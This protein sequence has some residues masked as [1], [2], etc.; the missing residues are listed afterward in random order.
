MSSV[1]LYLVG[2]GLVAVQRVFE[3]VLSQR[4]ASRA[5]A[6]G[7]VE[8]GQ[9]HLRA[10]SALHIAFFFGCAVE[11]WALGRP[12][13]ASV[14]VPMIAVALAA[15]SL[16]AWTMWS[17]GDAWN[18]R[19]IVV[20]G[21]PVVTSGP[22]RWLRHPNYLAVILEGVAIP[23]IHGAWWTAVAF[24]IA[25]AALLRVRIRCEE[26]ALA[27]HCDYAARFATRPRWLPG[28]ARITS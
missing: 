25:N 10:M 18:V 19:V 4:H 1:S 26:R 2:L 3:L 5:L 15:Q 8:V 14:G 17:L 22:Y 23:L 21:D 11:V 24:S 20:P 9:G 6:R 7:G 13:V 27:D 12:F 28:T 16:R